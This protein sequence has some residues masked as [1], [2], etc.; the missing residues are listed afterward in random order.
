MVKSVVS[1]GEVARTSIRPVAI[2]EDAI[3]VKKTV[4]ILLTRN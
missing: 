3:G 1:L 4:Y 2:M